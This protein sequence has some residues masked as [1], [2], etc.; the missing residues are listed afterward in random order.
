MKY[1]LNGNTSAELPKLLEPV[2]WDELSQ[3]AMKHNLYAIFHEVACQY[4]EYQQNPEYWTKTKMV[5]GIVAHQIR[6]T[7]SFLKL[8]QDFLD[9][10]IQ[11]IVMKGIICRQLYGKYAE[12]R[13]SGDEDIFVKKSHFD[14]TKEILEKNGFVCQVT[15]VTVAKLNQVEHIVFRNKQKFTIEVHLNL[16]G[17]RSEL[18]TQMGNYFVNAFDNCQIIDI[19]GVPIATMSHTEHYLYLI[20]HA[21]KHFM[22]CGVGMR[23]MLDVMM[24]QKYYEAQIDW[25]KI[26]MILEECHMEKYL[27]DIQYIGERYLGFEFNTVLPYCCP[28]TLLN[29][30]MNA[31]VFGKKDKAT[32]MAENITAGGLE[33]RKSKFFILLRAGFPTRKQMAECTPY[34]NEKPWM[35]P[36]EWIKRWGRY[37][38]Q[39]KDY[40]GNLMKDSFEKSQKRMELL[41]KY[42]L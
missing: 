4:I 10:G 30:V 33:L 12:H 29:D 11:P 32:V 28:D 40:S 3:I 37:F 39:S 14:K 9:E 20:M 15:D 8:Y 1:A 5:M 23:Q 19:E 6:R 2:D 27:G 38:R 22:G 21:F 13:P 7:D 25:H 34:L 26:N 36:I 42:G 24:Y 41:K 16:M 18:R 17:N 35:L 31:G